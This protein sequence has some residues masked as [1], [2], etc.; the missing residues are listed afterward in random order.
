MPEPATR[1]GVEKPVADPADVTIGTH[2]PRND[3]I[4]LISRQTEHDQLLGDETAAPPEPEPKLKPEPG[5]EESVSEPDAPAA[6]VEPEGE[7][8][9]AV[10]EPP[11]ATEED[12]LAL[13]AI[14]KKRIKLKIDGEDRVLTVEE[15]LREVQK[16]GAAD[17]RLEESTRLVNEAKALF[18]QAKQAPQPSQDAVVQ[19]P[20]LDE[21]VAAVVQAIRTGTDEEANYA[22]Q[23]WEQRIR[24]TKAILPAADVRAFVNDAVDFRSSAEWVKQEYADLFGDTRLAAMFTDADERQ[25]RAQDKRPYRERYTEIGESLRSWRDSLIRPQAAANAQALEQKRERKAAVVTPPAASVKAELPPAEDPTDDSVTDVIANI[26]KAR[27]QNMR[28]A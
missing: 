18:E 6:P 19:Q 9:P 24:N 3:M 15:A 25:V 12:F 14:G 16:K 10:A 27:G 4:D 21:D 13:D 2:N 5:E 22:A 17:K 11:V 8:K 1:K 28:G 23:Q 7:P 20:P 26:A